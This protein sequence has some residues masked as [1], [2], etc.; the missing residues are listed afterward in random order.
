MTPFH[1]DGVDLI[2]PASAPLA[3]WEAERI[4]GIGGSDVASAAGI[5]FD[6]PYTLWA[7]KTGR[8]DPRWTAAEQDRLESGHWHE[9]A[10]RQKFRTLHPEWVVTESPGTLAV[11]GHHWQRANVDGLV[12]TPEG[13][14]VGVFEA[15][16]H[17]HH[18][19]AKYAGDRAPV[20]YVCQV[21][22]Q[23][24][25]TGAPRGFLLAMID[26]HTWAHRVLERDDDLIGDLLDL[27]TDLWQ[28]VLD[29]T[30]PPVDGSGDTKR[31][32][33]RERERA[34]SKV[35]LPAQWEKHVAERAEVAEQIKELTA[36]RDLLDNQM[37]AALGE[38]QEAW[39]RGLGK[40]AS[41]KAPAAKR[42]IDLD[43]LARERPDVYA[44]YVTEED[45]SRR[46]TYRKID[47]T[48]SENGTTQERESA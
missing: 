25:V 29:D 47:T 20:P 44:E 42:S 41:H 40:V 15:K 34:G 9:P 19:A 11:P 14:L 37:R 35:I 1:L 26:T 39:I 32:L 7:A 10:I 18:Q 43:R 12:W 31:T 48:T 30:E 36:R 16:A 28:H 5:G 38:H 22:W 46:L 21:Q 27:A 24:H 23:M 45:A 17:D 4:N 13:E 33:A 8:V 3:E 2:L 6:S